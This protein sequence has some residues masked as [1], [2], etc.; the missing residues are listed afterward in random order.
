[1]TQNL[2]SHKTMHDRVFEYCQRK[3]GFINSVDIEE[4]KEHIKRTEGNVDG[5]LRIHREF[6]ALVKSDT[7]PNGVM[8]RLE[9][10][11][12]K[13]R[14]FKNPNLAIYE[15]IGKKPIRWTDLPV[16]RVGSYISKGSV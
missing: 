16:T 15:W 13:F 12:K 5:I 11:E 9:L 14:G 7:N 1:M 10:K 4:L 6:R 3:Q 8:R 2:F